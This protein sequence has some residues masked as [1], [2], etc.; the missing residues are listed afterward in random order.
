MAWTQQDLDKLEARLRSGAL[1]TQYED[2][3]VTYRTLDEMFTLRHVLERNLDTT[4][5]RPRRTVA[6]HSKGIS[7]AG[8]SA[9]NF[10][11][12]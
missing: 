2:R 10:S 5:Q 4:K 7:A 11:T 1:R 6:A 3:R 8:F 12:S 9:S